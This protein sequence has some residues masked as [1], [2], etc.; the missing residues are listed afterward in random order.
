M[1]DTQEKSIPTKDFLALN[2]A[3]LTISDTRDLGNDLSGQ[4]LVDLLSKA[5]HKLA[6]RCLLKDENETIQSKLREWI[7]DPKIQVIL[8]TGGTGISPRDTTPEAFSAV[9]EKEIPGFGELF[10]ILSYESIG[11]ATIQSR[12]C[13]GIAKG[14]LLFALP[15]SPSACQEAWEKII[16]AQL[17]IASRPCNFIEILRA[18]A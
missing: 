5:G 10:R 9:W 1:K 13:A 15:G 16:E 6:K 11:P 18:W 17:D 3:V 4:I 7:D 8:S 2:I 14:T 12:A